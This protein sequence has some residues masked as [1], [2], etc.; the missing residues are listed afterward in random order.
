MITEKGESDLSEPIT[1]NTPFEQ[2]EIGIFMDEVYE[3]IDAASENLRNEVRYCAIKADNNIEG[4]ITYDSLFTDVNTVDEIVWMDPARGV[5]D[6]QMDGVFRVSIGL[7]MSWEKDQHHTITI[8]VNDEEFA[9]AIE[10][11][12]ISDTHE[13]F[14]SW[15]GL[16]QMKAGDTISVKHHTESTLSL[17]TVTFCVSSE[18]I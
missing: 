12:G 8:M 11:S 2:T 18:N 6:A 5:F 1:L 3:A 14:A 7:E 10:N 17:K 16:I 4:I 9:V 13:E 15:E